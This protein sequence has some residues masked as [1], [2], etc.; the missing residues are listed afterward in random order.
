MVSEQQSTYS[1]G[2]C[3]PAQLQNQRRA[4]EQP[5]CEQEGL[6]GFLPP[7]EASEAKQTRSL[8][9]GLHPRVEE[10]LLCNPS[11]VRGQ[12]PPKP[13]QLF[14]IPRK[15]SAATFAS[16]CESPL[17]TTTED[18]FLSFLTIPTEMP[19]SRERKF[20]ISQR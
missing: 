10:V 18:G 17:L 8:L 16:G 13:C 15:V 2:A 3:E 20:G 14:L 12:N 11:Q 1:H 4:N 6:G 7:A 5:S 19:H 9:G